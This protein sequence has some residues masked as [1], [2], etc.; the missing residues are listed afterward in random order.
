MR[1]RTP[2]ALWRMV[3]TALMAFAVL[4]SL[5]PSTASAAGVGYAGSAGGASVGLSSLH[6]Y[7][8][9]PLSKRGGN[10]YVRHSPIPMVCHVPPNDYGA[11]YKFVVA[12]SAQQLLPLAGERALTSFFAGVFRGAKDVIT[13]FPHPIT[14]IVRSNR[15]TLHDGVYRSVGRKWIKHPGDKIRP[16]VAFVNIRTSDFFELVEPHS[17]PAPQYRLC[18]IFFAA[19]SSTIPAGSKAAA[20]VAKCAK[21][22]ANGHYE[23]VTIT[24]STNYLG[25]VDY[26][27]TLGLARAFAAQIALENALADLHA[28][29]VKFVTVHSIVSGH[30]NTLSANR[31]AT[32]TGDRPAPAKPVRTTTTTIKSVTSTTTTKPA[33]S[34]TTTTIKSVTTTTG[35]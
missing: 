4:A 1:K 13:P 29:A 7:L 6:I 26:N 30:F 24:G 15:I 2:H 19:G 23:T 14:C 21:T 11:P 31:R 8:V 22:I 16:H 28:Q 25:P 27:V 17:A 35:T 12:R 10:Y 3:A 33:T 5:A 34:T 32:V 18:V 20:T 9:V